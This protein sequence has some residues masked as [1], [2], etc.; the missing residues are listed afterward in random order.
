MQHGPLISFL[1]FY[2]YYPD[3][4]K[5]L[6]GVLNIYILAIRLIKHECMAIATSRAV[7]ASD[8]QHDE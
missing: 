2:G 5:H 4:I 1:S 3:A 6:D 8:D 7:L